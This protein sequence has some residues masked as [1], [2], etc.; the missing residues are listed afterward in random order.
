LQQALRRCHAEGDVTRPRAALI[1]LVLATNQV[2]EEDSM[3]MLQEDHPQAAYHCGR[4]LAVLESI[5]RAALGDVNA[6]VVDRYYGTASTAPASVFGRLLRGAQPHLNKLQRDR[7]GT[8]YALEER[9]EQVLGALDAFPQT[10][11]LAEQGLFAL[12]YYH[13]RAFDRAQAA[14]RKEAR[15]A[16]QQ[17]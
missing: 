7:P 13:Q 11:D 15:A 10:L 17:A 4:L 5:Q 2:I 3:V 8:A 12:G 6:G 9:L 14:A 1:K 16:A